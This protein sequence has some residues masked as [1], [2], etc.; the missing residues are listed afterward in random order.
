M[1]YFVPVVFVLL[2]LVNL[3]LVRQG[4]RVGEI[5]S[6]I[7]KIKREESPTGF[8]SAIVLQVLISLVCFVA[9]V[10]RVTME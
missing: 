1:Q 2:G 3:N 10:Y 8:W 6:R 9:A 5:Q 4:L 7:L